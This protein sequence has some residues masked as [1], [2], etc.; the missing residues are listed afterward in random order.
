MSAGDDRDPLRFAHYDPLDER[1]REALFSL[2]NG[3]LSW[4]ASPPETAR[5]LGPQR[6]DDHYAGFYRAGWYDEAPR[7][8]AP[9]QPGGEV[10]ALGA[11]VNLPDP[12]GLTLR[13]G[14]GAWFDLDGVERLDYRQCLEPRL[15]LL[16]RRLR[17]R[18]D[19]HE[20]TLHEERFVSMAEADLAVLRWTLE[21]PAPLPAVTLRAT[22]DGA[23]ENALV[24]RDRAYEGRRLQVHHLEGIGSDALI[25][26]G[27]HSPERRLALASRTRVPGHSPRWETRRDGQRLVQEACI[28]WPPEGRLVLEKRVVVQVDDDLPEAPEAACAQV[29]AR[30]P[31]A[32]YEALRA[33]HQQAWARLWA[34]SPLQTPDPTLQRLLELAAFHVLQAVS[35]LSIGR[36]QGLPPKGWQEGYSGQ[37]FW[38]ELFAFPYL[39]TRFPEL[40]R[41]LLRYRHRRLDKARERAR[42]CGLRGALYPWRSARHGDE[43]TPPY[44]Y[45]PLSCRWMRDNTYLQRHIGAAIVYDVWQLYLATGDED[46]L[47]GDGGDLVLEIARFWASLAH[48]DEGL[49]RYVI[50]GVVG[51]DEYHSAYPDATEPGLR[52]NAY[53]NLMAAWTLQRALDLLARLPAERASALRQRLAV[54]P[55]ELDAWARIGRR[56]YLPFREDGVLDQFDGFQTLAPPPCSDLS[57]DHPRLDWF[58]ETR[59]DTCNRYQATKQPDVLMFRYLFGA[60]ELRA[61]FQHLGYPLEEE[62]GRRTVAYHLARVTHESSL[63]KMICAGALVDTEPEIAWTCFCQ[64]L[65]TDVDAP[66]DS[67]ALEGVHLGSLAGSL[68]V[69]QRHYLGISPGLDG[70]RV[71]PAPPAALPDIALALRYRGQR[72]EV[73]LCD[74]R[75]RVRLDPA[76]TAPLTLVHAAGRTCL[77]PGEAWSVQP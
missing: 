47:A 42:R 40:A 56:L 22:L 36:D 9:R 65:R 60:D 62:A 61:L 67:G 43:E 51:P 57:A 24:D 37:I 18:L 33:D 73:D 23:V 34:D 53:T 39:S 14:D 50:H 29:R 2:G 76:A 46:L 13:L 52:N 20:L 11:L 12:F 10:T 68:D 72:V 74:G 35:P 45:N 32:P 69:L 31:D 16:W 19:G 28:P 7:P 59:H 63:S 1:R 5:A 64:C 3:V 25:A 44:Q 38:D 75:V 70:L 21:A 54:A 8:A 58:L 48:Y 30:L 17:F 55:E 15:G 27:L 77:L 26:A 66:A 49:E 4:R 41:N 6:P 71:F